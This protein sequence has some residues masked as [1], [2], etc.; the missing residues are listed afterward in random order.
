MYSH[1]QSF[2]PLAGRTSTQYHCSPS[3]CCLAFPQGLAL[4]PDHCDNWLWCYVW[5]LLCLDEIPAALPIC[6]PTSESWFLLAQELYLLSIRKRK[7][8][9][10]QLSLS[11]YQEMRSAGFRDLSDSKGFNLVDH[12]GHFRAAWSSYH[13]PISFPST[14]L[15]VFTLVR[16]KIPK[17]ALSC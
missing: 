17:L 7:T 15:N 11:V 1:L 3:I 4:L 12:K 6:L 9:A 5:T 2:C 14:I 16:N 8:V 13:T 10:P